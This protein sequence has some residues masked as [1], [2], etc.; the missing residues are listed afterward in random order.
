MHRGAA[1]RIDSDFHTRAANRI[2]IQHIAEIG[3]VRADVI[4]LVQRRGGLRPLVRDTVHAS[5]IVF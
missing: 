1:Q 4:V 2:H 5:K 3:H